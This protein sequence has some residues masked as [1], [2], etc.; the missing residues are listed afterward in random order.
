MSS[1]ETAP[2]SYEQAR[3]ELA[4]V[5]ATLEAG[6]LTLD[7]SLKLWERG[8]SLAAQCTAFLDGAR[9]RVQAVLEAAEDAATAE[10]EQDDP[11]AE[12]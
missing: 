9:G 3:D 6:G 2:A 1:N 5:V 12:R 10:A 4:T 7:E 11:A 8:Q